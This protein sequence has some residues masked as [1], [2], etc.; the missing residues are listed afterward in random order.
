MRRADFASMPRRRIISC[1][2]SDIE[3][4]MNTLMWF[5]WWRKI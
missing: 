1:T 3:A 2:R 5:G 4:V